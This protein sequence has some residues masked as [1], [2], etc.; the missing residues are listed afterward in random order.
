MSSPQD[1][2]HRPP[3]QLGRGGVSPDGRSVYVT[4]AYAANVPQYDVDADGRSPRRLRR[5]W[6]PATSR[7]VSP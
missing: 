3:E 4:N 7:P 6:S 2:G 5:P 1:P